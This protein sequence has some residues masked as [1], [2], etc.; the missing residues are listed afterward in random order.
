[1]DEAI[2]LHRHRRREPAQRRR[3]LE[4]VLTHHRRAVAAEGLRSRCTKPRSCVA[5]S[6]ESIC[7]AIRAASSRSSAAPVAARR[8]EATEAR[9]QRLSVEQLHQD[10]RRALRGLAEVEDL[11]EAWMPDQAHRP[12]LVEEPLHRGAVLREPRGEHLDRRALPDVPVD[13][14]VDD[15]HPA[16]PELVRDARLADRR[17]DQAVATLF[18]G[19]GDGIANH[20]RQHYRHHRRG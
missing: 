9:P 13:S 6:A 8:G 1:M 12:R 5:I 3:L 15:A 17:A 14:V 10:V 11:H 19:L 18:A 2:E 4:E 20:A 16:A 7:R